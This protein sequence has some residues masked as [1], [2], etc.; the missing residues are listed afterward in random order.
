MSKKSKRGDAGEKKSKKPRLSS[1]LQSEWSHFMQAVNS[2]D[3]RR[4]AVQ[5]SFAFAFQEGVKQLNHY[6]IFVRIV[7]FLK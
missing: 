6:Y 1:S 7:F 2:F 4:A 5:T 3:R